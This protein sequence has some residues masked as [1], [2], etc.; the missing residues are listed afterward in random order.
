MFLALSCEW[1]ANVSLM[2]STDRSTRNG[3]DTVDGHWSPVS[4]TAPIKYMRLLL[5]LL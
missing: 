2:F 5:R 4:Q 1:N 3:Q